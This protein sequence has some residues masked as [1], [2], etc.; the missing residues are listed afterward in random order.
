MLLKWQ[1]NKG[2]V[3]NPR[4][5]SV[6]HMKENLAFFAVPLTAADSQ[7]LDQI[8]QDV[9]TKDSWYECVGPEKPP[10]ES[11]ANNDDALMPR[12]RLP[13]SGDAQI[14][15]GKT[16]LLFDPTAPNLDFNVIDTHVH[17]AS[18]TNGLDYLW[19]KNPVCF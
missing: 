1:W 16:P 14:G 2:V 10:L 9:C 15:T 19:A 3:V 18:T 8:P 6:S 13:T 4:T 12:P 17:L 7:T 5:F 11:I